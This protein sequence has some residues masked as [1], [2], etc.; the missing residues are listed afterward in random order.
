MAR[1]LGQRIQQQEALGRRGHLARQGPLAAADQAD[2]AHHFGRAAGH[3]YAVASGRAAMRRLDELQRVMYDGRPDIIGPRAAGMIQWGDR[4]PL[5]KRDD[6]DAHWNVLS[7]S[8]S[9]TLDH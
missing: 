6:R 5:A 3:S 1:A 4:W 9:Q 8:D 2:V 7:D